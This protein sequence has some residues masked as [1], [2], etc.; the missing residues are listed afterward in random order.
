MNV[1]QLILFLLE[2]E[3]NSWSFEREKNG[4]SNVKGRKVVEY[5][6]NQETPIPLIFSPQ[7]SHQSPEPRLDFDLRSPL[8]ET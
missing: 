8:H 5:K 7:P 3:V 2:R 6:L 4:N 1:L